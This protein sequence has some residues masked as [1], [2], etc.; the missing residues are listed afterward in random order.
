MLPTFSTGKVL[1]WKS[2]RNDPRQGEGA[3]EVSLASLLPGHPDVQDS[4]SGR[5]GREV[6]GHE[7]L[8]SQVSN[9]TTGKAHEGLHNTSTLLL[10]LQTVY[11]G[12]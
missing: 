8:P 5:G 11:L 10:L 3:S 4:H 12:G 6:C 2:Q 1:L 9:N 7:E